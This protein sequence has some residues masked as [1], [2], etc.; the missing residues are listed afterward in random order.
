MT[1]SA[2]PT[3]DEQAP[4]RGASYGWAARIWVIVAAWAVL[5]VARS[6]QVGVPFRD[7]GGDILRGRIAI[8]AVLFVVLVPIDALLRTRWGAQAGRGWWQVLRERW[9]GRRV[10]LAALA[11][12]AYHLVYFCYHN[13]KSW[14]AFNTVRDAMLMSWDRTLFAG[15][16]PAVLLHDLLGQHAA[17]WILAYWYETFGT[18]VIVATVAAV[19]FPTRMRDAYVAMT[20]GLWIWVL[21]TISY[22]LIPSLG[23]FHQDPQAFAHLPHMM[24]QDTQARYMAERAQFLAD[25]G[26]P[27]AF[28]QVSAF[29]SLHVGVTTVIWLVARYLRVRVFYPV[30]TVFLLG[31]IVATTYLGWHFFVDDLAGLFIG[32]LSVFLGSRVIY[33]WTGRPD[34]AER[35]ARA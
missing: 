19:V 25:P 23:P 30:M 10:L 17:A 26:A 20:A 9:T 27:G 1:S 7:P 31:T 6:I 34:V 24:I 3:L 14:D 29:A 2:V 11:L 5:A 8:S 33:P 35:P 12:L 22:Y 15:H 21:G 4:E 32:W 13:L 28:Q 18:L 16:T